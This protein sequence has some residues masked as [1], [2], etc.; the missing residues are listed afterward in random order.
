MER[1]I[2]WIGRHE[3]VGWA[4]LLLG[5]IQL[6]AS[7]QVGW[8]SLPGAVLLIVGGAL[9]GLA[10]G[11]LLAARRA[12]HIVECRE[13]TQACDFTGPRGKVTKVTS[14]LLFRARENAES[15]VYCKEQAAGHI[16]RIGVTFRN[17]GGDRD[18]AKKP[19]F[20]TLTHEHLFETA[21]G[22]EGSTLSIHPPVPLRKR[23]Y[24]EVVEEETI[25]DSF[26]NDDEFIEKRALYPIKKLQFR[27]VFCDG[28]QITNSLGRWY[29]GHVPVGSEALQ[30][31]AEGGKMV[32]NWL[33]Q[34]V[35][36]G[37]SYRVSWRWL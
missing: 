32:V 24:F 30:P 9:A 35:R 37:E 16:Q 2:R 8:T 31:V 3:G 13:C 12:K 23:E 7:P 28:L 36:A 11:G 14:Q 34:D 5:L 10:G 29:E 18:A 19:E 20:F 17:L 25:T 21:V 26:G 33:V 15:F 1:V 6:L 27:L 4:G 22:S